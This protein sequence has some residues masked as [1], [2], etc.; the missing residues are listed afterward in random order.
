VGNGPTFYAGSLADGSIYSGDLRTGDGGI[1]AVPTGYPAVGL[2]LD[3][4]GRRLFVAGGPSGTGTIYDAGTGDQIR[5]FQLTSE[6]TTFV[7][8]VA[9]GRNAAYFTDSFR[10]VIYV[11][12]LGPRGD[13]LD[14]LVVEEIPLGGDFIFVPGGFNANGISASADGSRLVVVNSTTGLLYRVDPFSGEANEI[15]LGGST[16][17]NGDGLLLEGLTLYVVQNSLNQ[18]AVAEL[19]PSFGTGSV[20][21]YLTSPDFR[22]PTSVASFGNSLY[23]VN[24]RF[25]V[26]ATPDTEYEIVAVAKR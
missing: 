11:V 25:D 1:L 9:V 23:A 3:R 20:V 8:A 24:A 2:G 14:P 12:P 17:P 15:D 10:P 7:N 21:E 4:S 19:A 5:A 18:I 6:A 16:F 26:P 13:L 22:V